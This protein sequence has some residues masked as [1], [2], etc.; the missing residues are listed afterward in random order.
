MFNSEQQTPIFYDGYLYGV[1]KRG[2]GRL[3][4]LDLEGNE[5]WNS[6]ADKFGHGPY[7]IADRLIY[8]M[9][10]HGQLVMA[11][12]T[13]NAYNALGR[14]QVFEDGRDAWGP[15]ALVAGRLIV[16]DMTQMACL[17]VAA[18]ANSP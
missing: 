3:V 9:D 13:T 8:A 16:R 18:P 10:N 15:M 5:L 12:A 4:C 6:G 14:C 11:E 2:G 1:R 17:D 7:M